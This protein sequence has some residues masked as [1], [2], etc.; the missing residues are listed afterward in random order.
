VTPDLRNQVILAGFP[1]HENPHLYQWLWVFILL[2]FLEE[3]TLNELAEKHGK[4][5]R[6]LY[7]ILRQ[8]PDAFRKLVQQISWPLFFKKMATY[9][10]RNE[11]YQSRHHPIL[12]ADDTQSE[13]FGKC[14][15]FV[16]KLFDYTEQRYIMAHNMV[17]ILVG[18]GDVVFPMAIT[19]WRPKDQP[20]HQSKNRIVA[21]FLESLKAE[22]ARRG[23]SLKDVDI[24]FDSAYTAGFVINAATDAGLRVTS[25]AKS[26]YVFEF[27]GQTCSAAQIIE[28]VKERTWKPLHNNNSSY[29]RYVCQHNQYGTV[30][31]VIRRRKRRNGKTNYDVLFSTQLCYRAFQV[32]HRYRLRWTIEM[33]FK[34]YKQHLMLGKTAYRTKGSTQSAMYCVALAG[35]VVA[36]YGQSFFRKMSF[37][38][39]VKQLKQKLKP[40]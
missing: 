10:Q 35:I 17:L 20:G 26:R 18:F 33:H 28:I 29:Q 14:I 12:I 2:P 6:A 38:T 21:D 5:L 31:L 34:Y 40:G 3:D 9:R 32:D 11:S 7:R 39:L 15:A 36:L 8:Y 37:K 13:K 22:A 30:V 1:Y 19:L 16:K 4:D 25:K 24:T 23:V 27:E